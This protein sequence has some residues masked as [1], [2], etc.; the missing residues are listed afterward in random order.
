MKSCRLFVVLSFCL[1]FSFSSE[2][3]TAH[4]Q[5]IAGDGRLLLPGSTHEQAGQQLDKILQNLA[6][7]SQV[8]LT[9]ERKPLIQMALAQ[10]ISAQDQ[11]SIRF[12]NAPLLDFL[13]QMMRRLDIPVV[14]VDSN[15]KLQ[16]YVTLHK[17]APVSRQELLSI[18]IDK[19]RTSDAV[20]VKSG[21][22]MQIVSYSRDWGEGFEPV[23]SPPEIAPRP[24]GIKVSFNYDNIPISD[25]IVQ[26]ANLLD[27]IPLV[28]SPAVRGSVT[29]LGAAAIGSEQVYSILNTALKNNGA[30]IIESAGNYQIVPVS[31]NVPQGWKILD[32][33]PASS[34]SFPRHSQR[35]VKQE[36]LESHILTRVEPAPVF[37]DGRRL[38]G[39]VQLY[40]GLSEQGELELLHVVA[41]AALPLAEAAIEA[42]RQ[43]H[44]KPFVD[45]NGLPQ[46][47]WAMITIVFNAP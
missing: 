29:L 31:R 16:G 2:R 32:S 3:I 37:A 28:I 11:N 35:V 45:A 44:F 6:D 13:R 21:S 18:F 33:P 12:D 30:A 17:D 25:F 46:R 10:T 27:I 7:T 47:V 5:R 40:I 14:L 41:P 43:W 36:E 8:E 9:R 34:R 26:I 1:L 20:L 38:T 42:V 4:P 23:T 15:V 39:E 24:T 22:I 19:L